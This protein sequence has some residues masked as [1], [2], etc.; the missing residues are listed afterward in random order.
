L[1]RQLAAVEVV[2]RLHQPTRMSFARDW[3]LGKTFSAILPLQ[4]LTIK[5]KRIREAFFL[6]H[7]ADL[8]R[9]H[10]AYTQRTV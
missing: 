4:I 7:L 10:V 8:W 2:C 3:F 9:V 6:L 1:A 5:R